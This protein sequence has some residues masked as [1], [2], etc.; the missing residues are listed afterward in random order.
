MR[1]RAVQ[2]YVRYGRFGDP[3]P[4]SR[5]P[6]P[7]SM[8]PFNEGKRNGMKGS[9]QARGRGRA[10]CLRW[11]DAHIESYRFGV[12]QNARRARSQGVAGLLGGADP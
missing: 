3:I 5:D 8:I 9:P 6:P 10:A 11:G 12:R 4:W 2:E 1:I 7:A